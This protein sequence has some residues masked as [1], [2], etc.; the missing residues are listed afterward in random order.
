MIL[1]DTSAL[2]ALADAGDARHRDA[3]QI[4]E[5]LED[6]GEEFL[7]HTYI[8]LETFALLQNRHGFAIA[9]KASQET[10]KFRTITV[11]RSLHDEAVAWLRGNPRRGPSLVDSV[12]F[13]VMRR[14]RVKEAFAFDE[15]FV[16]EGFRLAGTR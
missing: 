7:L 15:D 3:V 2:Y 8:L 13:L 5:R 1:V 14:E 10:R 6:E 12:S 16:Q 11:D 4:L 9:V